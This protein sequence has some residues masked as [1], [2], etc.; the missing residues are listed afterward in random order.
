MESMKLNLTKLN[1]TENID[2]VVVPERHIVY[3][4][5]H[6]PFQK[7]APQAW[8][9]LSKFHDEEKSRRRRT[10]VGLS[11]IDRTIRDPNEAMIYE[12]GVEVESR[13]LELPKGLK[14]KK[15][16]N[17]SYARFILTGPYANVGAA[18][19]RSYKLLTE[20]HV[21]FRR[22]F[23]IERYLSDEKTTPSDELQTE[24]LIPIV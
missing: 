11:V 14:Y 6:G 3:V 21:E 7:S 15:I 5:K 9:E 18:V 23:C 10:R 22:D 8:D 24:I 2:R 17:N 12:A 20:Q 13:P 16:G 1:L 4:E 19:V